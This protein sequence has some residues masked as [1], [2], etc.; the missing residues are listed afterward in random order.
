MMFSI[1][2]SM[3]EIVSLL[4]Q[5]T[6]VS[7]ALKDSDT[8]SENLSLLIQLSVSDDQKTDSLNVVS[9]GI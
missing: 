9:L 3:H 1:S 6:N 5:V 8:E 4:K 2:G 7:L